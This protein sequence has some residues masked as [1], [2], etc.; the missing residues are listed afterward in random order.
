VKVKA[1]CTRTIL[2]LL[3]ALSC[4]APGQPKSICVEKVDT[5]TQPD[6][7]AY[8]AS[9]NTQAWKKY[10]AHVNQ[11]LN[12]K[13]QTLSAHVLEPS[14][15]LQNLIDYQVHDDGAIKDVHAAQPSS[16]AQFDLICFEAI[17]SLSRKPVMVFPK[18]PGTTAVNTNIACTFSGPEAK[19]HQDLSSLEIQ[20]LMCLPVDKMRTMLQLEPNLL[21]KKLQHMP[22]P[23]SHGHFILVPAT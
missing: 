21:H 2:G 14:A 19:P 23:S 16:D 15:H 10:Y 7:S 9:L 5:T 20:I 3:F 6:R 22:R 12:S 4:A 11:L 17:I 8:F 1:V 13:I 18:T